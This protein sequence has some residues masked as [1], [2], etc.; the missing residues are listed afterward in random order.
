M[1]QISS[2]ADLCHF[3]EGGNAAHLGRLTCG[4]AAPAAQL[5]RHARPSRRRTFQARAGDEPRAVCEPRGCS[6][7]SSSRSGSGRHA[8]CTLLEPK[9][10]ALLAA[11][12]GYPGHQGTASVHARPAL[13][14][15]EES[16]RPAA[17]AVAL[18]ALAKVAFWD[19]QRQRAT[20][21]GRR[22]CS[23]ATAGRS[24]GQGYPPSARP[25]YQP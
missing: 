16:E 13:V 20:R 23:P 1:R 6:G 18:S 24:A 8:A 17:I 21:F 15:A 9:S 4:S 22:G 14:L 11:V 5:M 12:F 3:P 2:R 7:L 10:C 25:H 19:G